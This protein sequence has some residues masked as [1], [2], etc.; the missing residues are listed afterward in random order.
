MLEESAI[1]FDEIKEIILAFIH[2]ETGWANPLDPRCEFEEL[3]IMEIIEENDDSCVVSFE[4]LFDEDGFSQ[5]D[6][7]H[8][9]V[10][11]VKINPN[12]QIIHKQLKETHTGEA[13][14]LL[15]QPKK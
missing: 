8:L 9:L 15:Y 12:G 14:E 3:T 13:A 5:Y 4:Y 6:K 7:T 1:N 2:T 11:S 10:G